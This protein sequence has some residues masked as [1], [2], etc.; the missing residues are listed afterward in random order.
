[1]SE[2][3]EQAEKFL[4]DSDLEF[5]AVLVGSDCPTFCPDAAKERLLGLREYCQDADVFD[6][7]ALALM[8]SRVQTVTLGETEAWLHELYAEAQIQD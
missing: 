1:M 2:Y 3:T 7:T 8:N 4:K 5:R 6:M